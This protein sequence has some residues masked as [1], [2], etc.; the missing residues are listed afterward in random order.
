MYIVTF[1][2]AV[3]AATLLGISSADVMP[4]GKCNTANIQDVSVNY[5]D[6]SSSTAF[7]VVV[8]FYQCQVMPNTGRELVMLESLRGSVE[9]FAE[10]H[11]ELSGRTCL[12]YT[13]RCV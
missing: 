2:A 4:A 12:L 10:R 5:T 13:S 1:A 3:V 9:K 7:Q 11:L 6:V 8:I